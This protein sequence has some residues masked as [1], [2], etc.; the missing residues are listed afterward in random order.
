MED[1][2]TGSADWQTNTPKHLLPAV[3]HVRRLFEAGHRD[4]S[5]ITRKLCYAAL[6]PQEADVSLTPYQAWFKA[7][8]QIIGRSAEAELDALLDLGTPPAIFRA[9][10]DA[11]YEGVNVH[12][13]DQFSQMVRV[14]L[15]NPE[16]LK[17][18]P[19]EWANSQLQFLVDGQLHSVGRWVKYVCDKQEV[20]E[21]E[22][23]DKEFEEIVFRKQWRAPKFIHMQPAGDTG[24][25]AETAWAREDEQRT[26][27][28]LERRS[29]RFIRFLKIALDE[30]TGN[31][32]VRVAQ[33]DAVP[34]MRPHRDEVSPPKNVESDP[35]DETQRKAVI[36]KVQ[37][38]QA[39][40]TLSTPEAAQYFGVL[41]RTIHRW[42]V[43][44]NLRSGARRGS[45]TI[46]S[47][48]KWEKKR[49]RK[50]SRK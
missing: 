41:P 20:P 6:H 38:P 22:V 27:Q 7:N 26:Q 46:G 14:G 12:M 10:F 31:A 32:H 8:R 42:T 16:A 43:L 49:S 45:I 19:V 37:N 4:W 50:R 17:V 34:G 36:K 25:D 47:I 30:M 2:I 39:Y 13:H 3:E 35:W 11:Y 9:Y 23:V 1:T 33:T 40:R 5:R 24:Y 28:F 21:P 15:A 44:G 18:E 48:I 29:G